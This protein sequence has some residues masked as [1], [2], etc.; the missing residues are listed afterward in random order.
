MGGPPTW[1]GTCASLAD[2]V[3]GGYLTPSGPVSFP[4]RKLG[5]RTLESLDWLLEPGTHKLRSHKTNMYHKR[6]RKQFAE[7]T[8]GK[9]L[10][11]EKPY[12]L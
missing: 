12:G 11:N 3:R 6:Q 9:K 10:R 1:G 8:K 4:L 7:R 5:L 2:R